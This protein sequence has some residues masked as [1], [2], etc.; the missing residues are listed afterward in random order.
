[1][2]KQYRFTAKAVDFLLPNI[3]NANRDESVIH[4]Y[5]TGSFENE[6]EVKKIHFILNGLAINS[7][8]FTA[9]LAFVFGS[10][11]T[12]AK[13]GFTPPTKL[14]FTC[15]ENEMN[16]GVFDVVSIGLESEGLW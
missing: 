1:M 8:P 14:V 7:A 10:K 11:G 2:S 6:V 9:L 5:A 4:I 13:T 15:T 12:D 16:E 3:K